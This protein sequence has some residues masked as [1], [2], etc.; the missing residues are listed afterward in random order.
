MGSHD[1]G[2]GFP[3]V[4]GVCQAGLHDTVDTLTLSP[5]SR[6]MGCACCLVALASG[7]HAVCAG[8]HACVQERVLT[9]CGINP[10]VC[11]SVLVHWLNC[12]GRADPLP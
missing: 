4:R 3:V 10:T 1:Q 12:A 6:W 8:L 5:R 9:E 7:A 2:P 11:L